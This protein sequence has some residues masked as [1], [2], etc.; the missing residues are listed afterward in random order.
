MASPPLPRRPLVAAL[1]ALALVRC[2]TSPTSTAA[3]D[4]APA[5]AERRPVLHAPLPGLADAVAADWDDHLAP[6]FEHFHRHPELSFREER[7]AAR[8]A[9]ELRAAGVEVTE[10]V[11]GTG[12]VGMLRNGDGPLVLVRADMDGL[13]V[14][15]RCPSCMPAGT[16]CT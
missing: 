8:L 12:L 9:A 6:L 10:G 16:T 11:G 15:G 2:A 5:V 3:A 1:A 14:E 7:T 4:G 13:P